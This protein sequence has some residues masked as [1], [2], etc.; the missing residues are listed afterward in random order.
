MTN[1]A[2][3]GF[4]VV[5][6][7]VAKLV[8]DNKNEVEA[9]GGDSINIKYILDLRDFPDSPFSDRVI[10]DFSVIENDSEIDT[11]I[12]VM[13][14]S[15]PA[16]DYTV[17]ALKKGKNVISSNKEVVAN[18]G[19]EF[20][21][22]AKENGVCYRFE[23][24]V[25]GGIPALSPIISCVKQNKI[26][27]V[28]GILNGTTNYILTKMF[29]YGDDFA[30]ALSDAQAR[31]FAE[32]NPDADILGTDAC[33]KIAIL[34]ALITGKLVPTDSIPTTGIT[35]IRPEDVLAAEK[36]DCKIK[37]L[38]RCLV[39]EG[40][41]LAISVEP[42]LIPHDKLLAS[43]S[44]VFNAVELVGEPIGEVMFYGPGAGAGPT[45]SAV[46]G[47][48][49]QVMCSGTKTATPVF[50]KVEMTDSF[51]KSLRAQYYVAMKGGCHGC[52][53]EAFGKIAEIEAVG[54]IAFLTPMLTCDELASARAALEKKGITILSTIRLL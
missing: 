48:L 31:G 26:S 6:S 21:R 39:S 43:V 46:V 22:V 13:G 36:I 35:M 40:G 7:G 45:A 10:H 50:E 3:L 8:T 19:D 20:L 33:R 52:A 16:Y 15:H 29:S 54:E 51:A 5:G 53:G 49:M 12:E 34:A 37:L 24:A 30:S 47:D 27:E 18:F 44:G 1:I 11:V 25:G 23:A 9:L 2:I 38:G 14:G 17:R 32:R 28:R 41:E 4:G 42:T